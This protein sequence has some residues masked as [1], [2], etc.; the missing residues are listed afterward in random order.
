M[1]HPSETE[2]DFTPLL[3]VVLQLLMFFIMCVRFVPN[4]SGEL[5]KL[6]DAKE[7]HLVD[8]SD[9]HTIFLNL[10]PYDEKYFHDRYSDEEWAN[11][12]KERFQK[13]D[14]CIMLFSKKEWPYTPATLKRRL[15][16]AYAD[17]ERLS[18]GKEVPTVVVIR[19]DKDTDY[20]TVYAILKDCKNAGFRK[21]KLRA[22]K[23]SGG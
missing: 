15:E 14:P 21:L 16:D 10:R 5:I 6:P 20:A 13:G 23:K 19:A 3:D 22:F 17:E 1:S 9:S 18:N 4:Q 11:F 12:P 8:M 7:G 2:P